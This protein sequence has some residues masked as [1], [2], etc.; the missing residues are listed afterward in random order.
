M[1]LR[2]KND[3]LCHNNTRAVKPVQT[4]RSGPLEKQQKKRSHSFFFIG[5]NA[6]FGFL[7]EH[8]QSELLMECDKVLSS[9]MTHHYNKGLV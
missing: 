9:F 3:H 4:C 2:L 1:R 7:I 8:E 6:L 5:Y